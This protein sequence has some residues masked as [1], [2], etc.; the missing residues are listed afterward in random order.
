MT[1]A[2]ARDQIEGIRMEL[3]KCMRAVSVPDVDWLDVDAR[4]VRL[5]DLVAELRRQSC[6]QYLKE[7]FHGDE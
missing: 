7:A 5:Q 6:M 3:R 4:L 2:E 1:P